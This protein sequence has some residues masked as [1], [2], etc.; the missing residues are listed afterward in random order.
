MDPQRIW[1]PRKSSRY[2]R[3]QAHERSR[4]W[5]LS[6]NCYHRGGIHVMAQRV[7]PHISRRPR[8]QLKVEHGLD[9]RHP[10]L[11]LEKPDPPQIRTQQDDFF[12]AL[13]LLRKL[14]A[15]LLARRSRSWKKFAAAQN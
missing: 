3:S 12:D 10:R 11:L 5:P 1:R 14:H 8:L 15:A 7:P 6:R 9:E 4:A 2:R 13:R